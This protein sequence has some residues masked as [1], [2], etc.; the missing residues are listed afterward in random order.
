MRRVDHPDDFAEALAG[1]RREAQGRLRRRPRA[2]REICRQAAPYRGAG[3]RR[4]SRQRRAS[5]RARLLGA[6]PPP[7]GDRGSAC[8]RH[9]GGDAQGDDRRRGEGREGDRLFAAPARSSSSSMPRD[10]LRP[11]RFWFMEMNTR[12]QVEH[13]VT[14]MV[15]GIDLVEWQLRVAAGE[16]LPKTQDE[17]AL[18]GHAFEARLY[19][20]D[21]GAR[22]SC[23]RPARCIIW[24]F[25]EAATAPPARRDRRAGRRRDLALLRSDDRQAGRPRRRPAQRRSP[26]WRDALAQNRD[27]RLVDQHRLSRGAGR[28]T[29]ISPPA[30]SIPA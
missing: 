17:I 15:T 26:R 4:Q 27:R 29:R 12:L 6:A 21:A 28:A 9:D 19:A 25:R 2:G 3:V 8:A 30:M 16:K 11:D 5:V 23:R 14:E 18:C 13:P 20:E 1:A 7:E 24:R 22:A 10:G